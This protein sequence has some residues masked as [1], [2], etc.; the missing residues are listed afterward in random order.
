MY[1]QF[2]F[3]IIRCS[4]PAHQRIKVSHKTLP[5][6]GT[7]KPRF[8][9]SP[10]TTKNHSLFWVIVQVK[11]SKIYIKII[12]TTTRVGYVCCVYICDRV[13]I[14]AGMKLGITFAAT[15][16]ILKSLY[17]TLK[18]GGDI[19]GIK[20]DST[21][22]WNT[23]YSE[24]RSS[25]IFFSLNQWT[26]ERRFSKKLLIWGELQWDLTVLQNSPF[27]SLPAFA[28][29]CT[30]LCVTFCNNFVILVSLLQYYL[31][32]LKRCIQHLQKILIV[33]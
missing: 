27:L 12:N 23:R 4:I 26:F 18:R 24:I 19:R 8:N 10:E 5:V 25:E 16:N 20:F 14:V 1:L 28:S 3:T 13:M 2:N 29:Q 17:L 6:S 11:V 22:F 7:A 21:L 31:Q 30:P 15:S 33:I 32:R 9:I